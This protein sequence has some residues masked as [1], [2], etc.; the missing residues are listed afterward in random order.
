MM[1]HVEFSSSCSG[2]LKVLERHCI[3]FTLPPLTVDEMHKVQSYLVL[4][5]CLCRWYIVYNTVLGLPLKCV[6]C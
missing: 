6:C 5:Q 2:L 3:M 4:K 1:G